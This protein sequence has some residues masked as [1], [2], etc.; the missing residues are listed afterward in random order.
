MELSINLSKTGLHRKLQVFAFGEDA[1]LFNDFCRYFW[2]TIAA[3]I[4]TVPI[5]IVPIIKLVKL[6]GLAILWPFE[7]II[8]DYLYKKNYLAFESGL[9]F[10]PDAMESLTNKNTEFAI[11]VLLNA[12]GWGNCA[13]L[14]LDDNE[15][16]EYRDSWKFKY[17]ELER[18]IESTSSKE[19]F[20]LVTLF[21][22]WRANNKDNYD[23]ILQD[24]LP[25]LEK[26]WEKLNNGRLKAQKD[27][28]EFMLKETQKQ[29]N[30]E[31]RKNQRDFILKKIFSAVAKYTKYPFFILVGLL[32][33]FL[34]YEIYRLI[35]H[36]CYHVSHKGFVDFIKFAGILCLLFIIGALGFY[37]LKLLIIFVS[38]KTSSK[39]VNVFGEKIYNFS[40][41]IF[42]GVRSF[43]MFFALMFK[44]FKANYCPAIN[45]KENNSKS[46]SK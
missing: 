35:H 25:S 18:Y 41:L 11:S 3:F 44:T 9:N 19:L 20:R 23:K 42:G 7:K 12:Y 27:A 38:E 32:A 13:I 10:V 5:P 8:D 4:I 31:H 6:I 40:G 24:K 29:A 37:L 15:R 22:K 43:F 33:S 28:Q 1:P 46:E 26:V 45:W 39:K 14:P 17:R 30:R 21:S 2:L 36:I 34:I 16:N